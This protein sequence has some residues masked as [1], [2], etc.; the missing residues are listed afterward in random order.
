VPK[1]LFWLHKEK[2][3]RRKIADKRFGKHLQNGTMPYHLTIQQVKRIVQIDKSV[4]KRRTVGEY[5][6]SQVR[7]PAA[8]RFQKT[9]LLGVFFIAIFSS[10]GQCCLRLLNYIIF[11]PKLAR[12]F[13]FC[14]QLFQV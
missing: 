14:S 10:C 1:Y 3:E 8:S 5:G 11:L 6:A 9:L 7:C 2:V 13:G 12:A 4:A